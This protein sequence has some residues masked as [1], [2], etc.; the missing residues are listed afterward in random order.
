MAKD[1]IEETIKKFE[2]D[3]PALFFLCGEI[4]LGLGY[5]L[6]AE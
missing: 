1:L 5:L 4:N 6:I 2:F 3:E